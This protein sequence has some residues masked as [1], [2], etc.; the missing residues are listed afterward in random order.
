[1]NMLKSKIP[2]CWTKEFSGEGEKV[3]KKIPE[4]HSR[5][6]EKMEYDI[7]EY[8]LSICNRSHNVK[9][10]ADSMEAWHYKTNGGAR[11]GKNYEESA[12]DLKDS[13]ISRPSALSPNR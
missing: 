11:V 9:L 2:I 5:N 4:P 1:M 6:G 3:N 13:L 10:I 12:E 7:Y 8:T